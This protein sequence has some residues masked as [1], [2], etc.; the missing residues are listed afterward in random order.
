[1][2]DVMSWWENELVRSGKTC[3]QVGNKPI[4][5][6]FDHPQHVAEPIVP[7]V[8]RIRDVEFWVGLRQVCEIGIEGTDHVQIGIHS[9]PLGKRLE[10]SVVGGVHRE[11]EVQFGEPVVGYLPRDVSVQFVIVR[12]KRG[13]GSRV[14]PAATVP[15]SGARGI[16]D[17]DVPQTCTH[18]P[19]AEHR[20]GDRGSA[21]VSQAYGSDSKGLAGHPVMLVALDEGID[22]PTFLDPQAWDAR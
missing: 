17:D 16:D 19:V 2:T 20:L 10:I 3:G 1:M 21:D 12:E 5:G 13:D 14:G 4:A 7:A 9:R 8:V 11:H 6:P 18:H 15:V 22:E